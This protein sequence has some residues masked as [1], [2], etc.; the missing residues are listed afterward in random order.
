MRLIL[1]Y[2]IEANVVLLLFLVVYQVFLSRETNFRFLRFFMLAGIGV[3][4]VFPLVRLTPGDALVPTI[5]DVIPAH[6][7]PEVLITPDGSGGQLQQTTNAAY[8]AWQIAGWVYGAGISICLVWL[9]FQLVIFALTVSRANAYRADGFRIIE[10]GE[11]KPTF[12]FFNI[13]YIG[14]AEGLTPAEKQQIIVHESVHAR[15][16]HSVDI[17]LITILQIIFWF[18]P[19]LR[20][21]KKIFIQLHEFEADARAVEHSDVNKYCSLLARVALQSVD[22]PIA[23]HF[24][25]SLTVK[26]IE[27]MRTIK[28]KMRPWKLIAVVAIVPITFFIVACQ[29]QVMDQ[30]SN[31]TISQ[32]EFPPE[33]RSHADAYL[34][35][36]PDAKLSYFEGIA[37]EMDKFITTPQVKNNIVYSYDLRRDNGVKKKG[38]L[39]TNVTQYA[40]ALQTDEKV[41]MVVEHQPEYV[42]GMD[43]MFAYLQDN[44]R[45]PE[46][47]QKAG[48][49][50]TVYIAMV[51]NEDGSVSDTKV[52]RGVEESLDA[53]ALRVVSS[54]PAW[55]PGKQNGKTVK[56][57]FTIPIRFAND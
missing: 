47:A 17:L 39:V 15:Q 29:D 35:K 46:K 22:F 45:Y 25:H 57:R 23:S 21:Y 49:S 10:S 28:K 16:W 5:S 27:M 32:S 51:I 11:D 24:N 55:I 8:D 38:V 44:I 41:Y 20:N 34:Q 37:E 56:V 3:A 50:G 14:K 6:W 7:L 9:I 19:F 26:R 52:L 12:S 13:I 53:E 42:G 18:N 30:L 4:L 54:F 2:I 1:N 48:T 40:E 36:H 43:A 33:I 31:S